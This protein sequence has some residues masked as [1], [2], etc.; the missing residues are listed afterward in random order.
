PVQ[1]S[2]TQKLEAALEP[3][4]LEIINESFMHNVPKGSE[5]HFKV[6][7]VAEKFDG[8]PLIKRHRMVNETLK[9]ELENGVH[10]LSITAKTPQQWEDSGHK[11]GKSPPC[12]GGAGL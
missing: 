11:V 8:V 9:T 6:V 12:R 3:Q 1:S 4:H 10:A 2:I 5:T 7:I